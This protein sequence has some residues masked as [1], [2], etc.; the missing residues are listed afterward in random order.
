[1][2]LTGTLLNTL[3]AFINS[4]NLHSS[5]VHVGVISVSNMR[6]VAQRGSVSRHSYRG[7]RTRIKYAY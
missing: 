3:R 2:S 4:F 7:G 5:P 6:K 1:M